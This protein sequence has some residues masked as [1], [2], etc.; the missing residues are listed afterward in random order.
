MEL[1][2][3]NNLLLANFTS[4]LVMT[5]VIWLIQMVHYPSFSFVESNQFIKFEEIHCKQISFIVI[6]LMLIEIISSG[7]LVYFNSTPLIN[8]TFLLNIL[9]WISTF[10]WSAPLHKKLGKG[11]DETLIKK[12]VKTNIPRTFLWTIRSGILIFIISKRI[13]A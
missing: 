5:G 8:L 2:S 7:F 13:G 12:L 3:F 11:K 9:I 6:P 10:I 4:C 1:L